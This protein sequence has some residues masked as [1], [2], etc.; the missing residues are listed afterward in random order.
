M[1]RYAY[2]RKPE[3]SGNG[4]LIYKVMVYGTEEGFYLFEYNS[5][6]AVL[7][8]GDRLYESSDELYEEWNRLTDERGWIDMDDPLP[9]CQH[10]GFIPLRVRG[11]D[12]GNP[13]WGVFETLVDGKW[14]EFDALQT[15]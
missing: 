5:L 8:S 14:I 9:G 15:K 12:T 10:D 7:S 11:R 13:Q 3:E 1:R 6:D 2:L 4:N